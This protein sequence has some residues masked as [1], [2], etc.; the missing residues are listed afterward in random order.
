MKSLN[1]KISNKKSRLR[2]LRGNKKIM[3]L[4]VLVL[5]VLCVSMYPYNAKA[6]V[7][8]GKGLDTTNPIAMNP[9]FLPSNDDDDNWGHNSI[10]NY[11]EIGS[12]DDNYNFAT[13]VCV[14][15]NLAF[16]VNDLEGL[17]IIDI[18]S[19][20]SPK[21]LGQLVVHEHQIWDITDVY[22]SGGYVYIKDVTFEVMPM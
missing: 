7:E 20:S 6:L 17:L 8:Q 4:L 10:H 3:I 14:H 19:P 11:Q 18:S 1:G 2:A 16:L 12:W 21:V 5:F 9:D 13:D 22:Y 15:D